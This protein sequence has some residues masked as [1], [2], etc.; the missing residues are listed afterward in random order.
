[1]K[2]DVGLQD[3][4]LYLRS[5]MGHM[6]PIVRQ[7]VRREIHFLPYFCSQKESM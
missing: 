4:V 6:Q 3:H 5:R 7:I 1:M 2:T